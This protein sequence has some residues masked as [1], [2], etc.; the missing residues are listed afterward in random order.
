M[1]GEAVAKTAGKVEK[2][3]ANVEKKASEKGKENLLQD[4][5]EKPA[6]KL[7]PAVG[8]SVGAVN[9]L[10][11]APAP[12]A[13]AADE[14]VKPSATR[15]M[16]EKARHTTSNLY[17]INIS[18]Y[19]EDYEGMHAHLTTSYKSIFEFCYLVFVSSSLIFFDRDAK[20]HTHLLDI[21]P[22]NKVDS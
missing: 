6:K 3:A 12:T 5:A 1:Q 10:A 7:A 18:L 21:L 11:K 2:T 15:K 17:L 13:G 16:R 14:G 8:V 20:T 4:K 19:K 22:K 9:E